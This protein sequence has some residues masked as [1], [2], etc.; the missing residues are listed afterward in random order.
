MAASLVAD[1]RWT[2]CTCM[3]TPG[4]GG[5]LGCG[6]D[7]AWRLSVRIVEFDSTC[8]ILRSLAALH[9]KVVHASL[10]SCCGGVEGGEGYR[11]GR[12]YRGWCDGHAAE[13]CASRV[14]SQ[15]IRCGSQERV[16][17]WPTATQHVHVGP[18]STRTTKCITLLSITATA[19]A[20]SLSDITR[21]AQCESTYCIHSGTECLGVRS[22]LTPARKHR[23]RP[24]SLSYH[25]FPIS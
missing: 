24:S 9:R 13:R 12:V 17:S 11:G 22:N 2:F 25:F 14:V 16:M 21:F 19:L 3:R 1:R 4:S 23:F 7:K 18:P 8:S 20:M 6:T 15:P 5:E 10:P